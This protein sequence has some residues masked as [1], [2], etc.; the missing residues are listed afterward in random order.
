MGRWACQ[1]FNA[2]QE[3]K[4]GN[5]RKYRLTD[6]VTAV[7]AEH[8]ISILQYGS[9]VRITST[10]QADG[11]KLVSSIYFLFNSLTFN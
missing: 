5:S 10:K 4:K 6:T 3:M 9:E 8:R 1:E 7:F 2:D 11:T